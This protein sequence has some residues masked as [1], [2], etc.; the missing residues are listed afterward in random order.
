MKKIK[1]NLSKVL[2]TFENVME[3]GAFAPMEQMLFFH[4]I[5][6]YIVF[7]RRQKVLSWGNGLTPHQAYL[8]HDVISNNVAFWQV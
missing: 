5:F 1:K 2:N 8:S 3:T 7:H 6:K 4:D